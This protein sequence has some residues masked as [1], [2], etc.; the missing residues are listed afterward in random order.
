MKNKF[1]KLLSF[2]IILFCATQAFSSGRL[3]G[4]GRFYAI[5]DENGVSNLEKAESLHKILR[6]VD[7]T[8]KN[9]SV[10]VVTDSSLDKEYPFGV[11]VENGKIVGFGIHIFNEDVYPL[12]SFEIYLRNCQLTG[13]IDLS[14]Y[15]D[16][17]FLDVYHN[18]ITGIEAKNMPSMRIFGIQ[19]NQISELDV[20]EL[21]ACQ[22][23]DA[24]F[25]LLSRLDV[26]KNPEL[27]ELYIN[28]NKFTE[29][30]LSHNPKL[31]YFYCHNNRIT[32]LDTTANPLL[33]HLNASGNPMK[34]IKS[35][36][37]QRETLLPLNITAGTGGSIGLKYN[38]IYNAQW[39]ETGEWEQT[40]FAYPDSGYV[41][42]GWY[43][44]SGKKVSTEATWVDE[45][46]TSRELTAKFKRN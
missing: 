12:Q 38:P 34:S 41:F 7:T 45:Y 13:T 8:N 43:D 23:I 6:R 15:T 18:K 19:D 42:E 21:P 32:K 40:Y 27:V 10:E 36:A 30:D 35:Y 33:R 39:K 14:N 44:K 20:S 28:D 2:L 22:G 31:K 9:Q 25:N 29:I 1:V 11:A 26:S 24:G 17:V 4:I 16:M 3:D 37:P 5:K 46:G